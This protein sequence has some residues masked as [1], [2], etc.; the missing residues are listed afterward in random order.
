MTGSGCCAERGSN[1]LLA[2]FDTCIPTTLLVTPPRAHD[3][4]A[5]MHLLSIHTTSAGLYRAEQID[6]RQGILL[7]HND[8]TADAPLAP[9]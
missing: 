5:L 7:T 8:E 4:T 1:R 9:S 2:T 6:Q 3:R